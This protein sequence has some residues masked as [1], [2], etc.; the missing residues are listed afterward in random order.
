[1]SDECY[2]NSTENSKTAHYGLKR[3][4]FGQK[5]FPYK[6]YS[7]WYQ[8]YG[9]W[10]QGTRIW[11]QNLSNMHINACTHSLILLLSSFLNL[12]FVHYS[13]RINELKSGLIGNFTWHLSACKPTY[14]HT[15]ACVHTHTHTHTHTNTPTPFHSHTQ[16]RP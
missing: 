14:T 8:I 1:M 5:Y 4:F 12:T 2:F 3:Q 9:F 15:L 11:I 7:I 13:F 6:Y 16:I 10:G